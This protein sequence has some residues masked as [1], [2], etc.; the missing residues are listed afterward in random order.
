MPLEFSNSPE[1][2]PPLGTYSHVVTSPANASLVFVSGQV[3]VRKDGTWPKSFLEQADQV[4]A[5]LVAHLAAEGLTPSD[6]IKVNSY[7]VDDD[8]DPGALS[9]TRSKYF[10]D[11]RPAATAV[12][13]A[14]LG[15]PEWKLEVELIAVRS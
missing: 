8:G 4:F 6:V 1:V 14:G 15:N 10:G 13:I 9:R 5:N 3:A 12:I 2:H 7:I 11:H